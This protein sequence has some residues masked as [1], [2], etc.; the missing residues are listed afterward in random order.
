VT[1]T[2]P[3][4][5]PDLPVGYPFQ[6][7]QLPHRAKL[8]QNEAAVD[9]PDDLKRELATELAT[10][11]WHRY[12]QP[13]D[14]GRAKQALADVVG[15][16]PESL[17]ITVGADQAI[18]AAF[19][20]AGGPGR[21][22]RWF[23]PTYP[24][25][26]TAARRTFTEAEPVVLG[27]DVD[28]RLEPAALDGRV[29]L[30]ALVSPNNPTGGLVAEPVLDAALADDRRLVLVDEAYFEFSQW[31]ALARLE[32]APNLIIARSL[33]K[34]MLAGVHV[35]CA[36]AHPEIVAV[37]ERLYTA[38]Y[39]LDAWQLLCA[40]RY[41]QLRPHV[42]AAAAKTAAERDRVGA[43]LRGLGLAV[44]DSAA[45]FVAFEIGARTG[46]VWRGL[47]EAGV[48]VRDLGA[49]PG[50]TGFLRVTVGTAAENDLFLDEL[51]RRL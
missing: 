42:R 50:L 44:L 26:A 16:A 22:A 46:D 40:E 31:T 27:R 10:R 47:A 45:N 17:A 32:R 4:L 36:I 15:V 39:H 29:D 1:T 5:R 6:V 25:I 34:S 19:L 8:D 37:I 51:A 13:A 3:C 24:F 7:S 48:R 23:E 38:P 49:L 21:R 30:V 43:A 2:L 33:S 9:V 41:A 11:A 35:G 14:Y 28:R 18:E 20:C 12:V